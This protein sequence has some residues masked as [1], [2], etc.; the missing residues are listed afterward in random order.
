MNSYQTGRTGRTPDDYGVSNLTPPASSPNSKQ[1][2][3][4]Q[5]RIM[6]GFAQDGSRFNQVR[7]SC[8]TAAQHTLYH[9]SKREG[10]LMRLL[11]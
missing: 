8:A 2:E 11:M 7:A 6:D 10:G 3:F 4:R 5:D 1:D 9:G